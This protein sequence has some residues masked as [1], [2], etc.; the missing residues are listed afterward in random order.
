MTAGSPPSTTATTEL[1]VPRSMPI[2]FA[3]CHVSPLWIFL[4]RASAGGGPSL[5][6]RHLRSLRNV[7]LDL[8]GSDLLGLGQADG[9][10]AIAIARLDLVGLN[11]NRE[12][13]G[14]LEFPE[15]PLRAVV[16]VLLRLLVP[17]TLAL[18]G[19]QVAGD[20]Q[21]DVLLVE[22]GQV[23]RYHELVL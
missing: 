14:P 21:M 12:L 1:V 22:P 10:H 20:G 16:V 5:S 11:R 8:L 23:C 4:A 18:E 19:Q 6:R 15:P 9:Q 2:T 17:A 13:E 7:D 3:M